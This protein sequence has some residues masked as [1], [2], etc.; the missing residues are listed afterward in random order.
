MNII[1]IS[2]RFALVAYGE[3]ANFVKA[4]SECVEAVR[5]KLSYLN[6][7]LA[8]RE[9]VTGKLSYVDI[10]LFDFMLLLSVFAPELLEE[11]PHIARHLQTINTL[12]Q[13]ANY[14]NGKGKGGFD[15][16]FFL[17]FELLIKIADSFSS[18]RFAGQWKE[19]PFFTLAAP[20][21]IRI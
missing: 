12:P 19:R 5:E 9:Y 11:N 2:M 8:D 21:Q 18:S 10:V 6:N 17:Y 3:E 13:I 1:Q 20:Y 15:F 16:E 4:R 14:R 7:L